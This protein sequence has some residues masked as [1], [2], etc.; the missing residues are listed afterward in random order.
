MMKTETDLKKKMKTEKFDLKL[1]NGEIVS[2]YRAGQGPRIGY[3]VGG[4][5]SFYFKGLSC[6]AEEYTFVTCDT[7]TYGKKKSLEEKNEEKIIAITK[8]KIIQRDHLI[9]DA[10]KKEMTVKEI[11]GF[12][13]SAPGG[14][15]FE[16]GLK[17]PD[18]FHNF[19]GTGI[20]LTELDP[21]FSKTN[22]FFLKEANDNRKLAF[23]QYQE[24][25]KSLHMWLDGRSKNKLVSMTPEIKN[26]FSFFDIKDTTK[27]PLNPGKKFLVET[28]AM[29][30]KLLFDL[31]N[32]EYAREHVISHWKHNPWNEHIDKRKQ[33]HFFNQV[34]PDL[35]PK[36][37]LITL[38]KNK[39]I[40]LIFG[41]EDFVT[42]LPKD[43]IDELNKH[44]TI[45]LKIL[46]N[47]SHMPYIE[48]SDDYKKL[49]TEFTES[50]SLTFTA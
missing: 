38:A 26:C 19:I 11:D 13:F 9:V 24:Q 48:S 6:L 37:S 25:L 31:S 28:L 42:P 49:V 5:G 34:F 12:G 16:E 45:Q 30:P 47:C 43:I 32:K 46:D 3:I 35:T 4:P 23:K 18:D 17:H 27:F 2:L 7:W 50:K 20:G 1:E 22:D 39:K 40:L 29:M 44:P 33:E 8:E 14:F 41:K 10:L 36:E 15:L 21:T